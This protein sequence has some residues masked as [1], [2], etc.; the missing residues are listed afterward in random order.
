MPLT[1][2]LTVSLTMLASGIT[3]SVTNI[4]SDLQINQIK[5]TH[6]PI[7]EQPIISTAA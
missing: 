3:D 5:I 7:T 2:S 1:M 6:S 4:S